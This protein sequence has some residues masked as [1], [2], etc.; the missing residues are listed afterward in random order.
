MLGTLIVYTGLVAALVGVMTLIRPLRW[1]RVRTRK[2]A[3]AVGVAGLAL[4]VVGMMLPAREHSVESLE[5]LLDEWM[6]AWQF[7]EFHSLRVQA[8]PEQAWRAIREVT[9]DEILLLRT[10][11]SI[12]NPRWPWSEREPDHILNAPGNKPILDVAL[13]GGFV[14]LGE[15][16]EPQR[17]R[18]I[19]LGAVV[20]WDGVTQFN[21][22]VHGQERI[23]RLLRTPGNAVATINF[24]VRDEGGG[25]VT[26]TTETRV[27]ATDL[28][29]QRRFARYWRVI[30]PGSSLLRYTWLR[31]IRNR[32]EGRAGAGNNPRA[33]ALT[34]AAA[35]HRDRLLY[36]V[37]AGQRGIWQPTQTE[38]FAVDPEGRE[39]RLIF[40]DAGKDFLLLL[41]I[42]SGGVP[43][44]ALVAAGTRLFGHGIARSRSS[45]GFPAERGALYEI[46]GD[47]SQHAR[48]VCKVLG[49]QRAPRD[50]FV[51]PA[52]D[53]IGYIN[54]I[55]ARWQIFIH[56]TEGGKLLQQIPLE[57]ILRE[58]FVRNI[59]WMPDGKQIFF[60]AETGD[61]HVTSEEA[62]RRVG[63]Y[64]MNED[65]SDVQPVPDEAD[66]ATR[67]PGFQSLEDTPPTMLGVLPDGR[68]L[69]AELQFASGARTATTFYYAADP[70]GGTRRDFAVGDEVPRQRGFYWS[71]LSPCGR[72]LLFTSM[73]EEQKNEVVWVLN[74]QTGKQQ[75]VLAYPT[76]SMSFPFLSIIG[77]QEE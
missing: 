60:T 7:S 67:R 10:L 2:Q 30:Y 24:R 8:T 25:R 46:S 33:A 9:G 19:V 63:S 17:P 47:G 61:V 27:F 70:A 66:G 72:F 77:W 38:I 3:A 54:D 73:D 20:L 36:A 42:R 18:E 35:T 44:T 49:E 23:Q 29:A 14:L 32:A 45:G 6:P 55:A 28:A 41:P 16:T 76:K 59:G 56:A 40:S 26:L 37:S 62:T 13:A 15:S 75:R 69:F 51:S 34:S 21:E 43:G 53:K 74:L 57:P 1:L 65:G 11:T 4:V 5:S 50:V 52:G 58:G 31:A 22:G 71:K 64:I 39:S 48:E 68:Y 12:R